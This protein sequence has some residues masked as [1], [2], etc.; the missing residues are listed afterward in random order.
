MLSLL[1]HVLA[2]V[3]KKV[4]PT[5]IVPNSPEKILLNLP[6]RKIPGVLLHQGEVMRTYAA[7]TVDV[8]DV[9]E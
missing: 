3:F 6:R 5:S 2:M 9:A 7:R 8:P 1:L 4:P